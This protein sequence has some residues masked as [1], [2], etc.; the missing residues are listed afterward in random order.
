MDGY[1][2]RKEY[3]I[4]SSLSSSKEISIYTGRHPAN[5]QKHQASNSD[6]IYHI[7]TI[8]FK[9]IIVG[10][11]LPSRMTAKLLKQIRGD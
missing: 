11:K 3:R 4:S 7:C 5:S 9:E 8:I 1:R 10:I 6:H 2:N